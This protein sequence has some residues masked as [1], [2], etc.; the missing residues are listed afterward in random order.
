MVMK[1]NS[2]SINIKY[3]LI[4]EQSWVNID[5]TPQEYFDLEEYEDIET[6]SIPLF[7]HALDYIKTDKEKVEITQIIIHDS[8]KQAQITITETFWGNQDNRI[9]ERIDVGTVE[10]G[11]L[12]IVESK[13]KDIPLI[14]E[15][16]RFNRKEGILVPEYHGFITQ[17]ADGSE[18]EEKI[19]YTR[20]V[21]T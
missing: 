8:A 13:I 1:N 21:I 20:K 5:L 16:I 14:Y 11:E 9:I 7:N 10:E 15:V 17:N 2:V 6:D 18:S 3:K 12:I 4:H 19:G